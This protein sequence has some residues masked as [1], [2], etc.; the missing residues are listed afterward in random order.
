MNASSILST[1][2]NMHDAALEPLTRHLRTA[3]TLLAS[4]V[5]LVPLLLPLRVRAGP[6]ELLPTSRLERRLLVASE[7]H[8]T[9]MSSQV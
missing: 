8:A 2:T 3:T 7:S 6:A 9:C 5:S 1:A 4:L